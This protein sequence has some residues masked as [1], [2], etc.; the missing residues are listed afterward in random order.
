MSA[1]KT[2]SENDS[3]ISHIVIAGL[4]FLLDRTFFDVVM[5]M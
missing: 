2:F 3:K 5:I 4:C 1:S